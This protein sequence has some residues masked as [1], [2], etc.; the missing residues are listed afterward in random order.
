MRIACEKITGPC[1]F[2]CLLF[3]N[4][5]ITGMVRGQ[6]SAL[7]FNPPLYLIYD[8]TYA[9]GRIAEVELTESDPYFYKNQRVRELECRVESSGLLNLNGLYRSIVTDDY[10]LL[11]FRS[12]EGDPG[13]KRLIEY[14]F[15]YQNRSA[16]IIDSRIKGADTVTANSIIK[17]IDKEYFDTV[18]MIFRIREGVDTMK[19]PAFI[20]I[21]I[22]GKQDS[23]L[24]ESILDVQASG[25]EGELV[26]AF[27][28]KA[29]LPYPPYP[30]FGDRIEIYISADEDRVPLRGRIQMALGYIEIKLRND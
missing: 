6:E 24:V 23:I 12:D 10:S 13:N 5:F 9:G 29:R 27:L 26:D 28:I 19:V 21:F 30:G 4:V 18:S 2:I 16:T 7:K 25:R 11:Y 3:L 22:E 1:L 17:N 20:P 14:H 15:D 8:V